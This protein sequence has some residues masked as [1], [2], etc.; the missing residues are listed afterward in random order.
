MDQKPLTGAQILIGRTLTEDELA[1]AL[2]VTRGTIK[3][4][5][6]RGEIPYV[7]ISRG[8][9]IYLVDSIYRW[10][11]ASE[12]Y[13]QATPE[14]TEDMSTGPPMTTDGLKTMTEQDPIPPYGL[15]TVLL[16]SL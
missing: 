2:G 8:K 15:K 16:K 12:I 3:G 13:E 6:Y 4:L 5:R 7:Q 10:L 9:V 14:H 11:V 1:K